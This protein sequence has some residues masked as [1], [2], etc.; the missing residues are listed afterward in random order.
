[1]ID[2]RPLKRV[3][4]RRT[5]DFLVYQLRNRASRRPQISGLQAYSKRRR[6]SVIFDIF[7]WFLLVASSQLS[8]T[9]GH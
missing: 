1:M 2:E 5:K 6:S 9:Y 4:M 8:Q 3:Q 7:S